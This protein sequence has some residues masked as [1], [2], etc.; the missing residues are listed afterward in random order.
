MM[1]VL[2]HPDKITADEYNS[3]DLICMGSIKESFI[4][5]LKEKVYVPIKTLLMCVDSEIFYPGE[6]PYGEKEYDWIFVGNSK[7]IKRKSE[8]WAVNNDVPLKIW[9]RDWEK[10]DPKIMQ[11]VVADHIAND[12]L[13][14]LYRNARITVDDHFEDMACLLYTSKTYEMN[15]EIIDKMECLNKLGYPVLLG[16]SRKSVIGLTLDL[17]VEEREEGTLVTTVYGVQKGCA[18]VRVH[19]VQKNLRA[20][21]MTQAI[22]REHEV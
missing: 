5:A 8:I 16:T 21:R 7:S 13:P 18:F 3:Y 6:D 1:W 11:H 15:L 17:P 10:I 22:M 12:D 4:A 2:S 19:D 9:G 14:K 20:I